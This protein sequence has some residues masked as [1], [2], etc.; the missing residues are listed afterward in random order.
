M[1]N[2]AGPRFF[3]EYINKNETAL[4]VIFGTVGKS[5]KEEGK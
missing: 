5:G 1:A 4:R 2:L 3:D